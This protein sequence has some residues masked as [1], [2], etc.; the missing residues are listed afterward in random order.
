MDNAKHQIHDSNGTEICFLRAEELA[1]LIR[2]REV[3]AE[4][5]MAACIE[6][7]ERTNPRVNAIVTLVPELAMREARVADE[8]LA[9]ALARGEEVGPLHG[10]PVAHKDLARPGGSAPRSARLSTKTS[11]PRRTTSSSSACDAPVP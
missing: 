9:E 11:S 8:R 7:I 5:A 3:S 1:R 10:L 4:E 2:G 6:Q